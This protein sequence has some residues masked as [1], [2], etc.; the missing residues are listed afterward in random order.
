MAVFDKW[1]CR[2][3]VKNRFSGADATPQT[4]HWR[5]HVSRPFR[6]TGCPSY[7]SPTNRPGCH[8]FILPPLTR[9][10]R[11]SDSLLSS[12]PRSIRSS[13]S[14]PILYSYICI[15][16]RISNI[17]GLVTSNWSIYLHQVSAQCIMVLYM[18]LR[19]GGNQVKI[20][21][22]SNLTMNNSE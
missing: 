21:S 3:N 8:R 7:K 9:W 14:G 20:R 1:I 6:R 5:L 4:I 17:Q 2:R 16:G 13:I 22:S 10:V 12:Y 11:L 19:T 15:R 18:I